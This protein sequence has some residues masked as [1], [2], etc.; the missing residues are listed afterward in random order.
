L[1]KETG[2]EETTKMLIEGLGL[3]AIKGI[4]AAGCATGAWKT[5]QSFP[6]NRARNKLMRCFKLGEMCVKSKVTRG[7]KQQEVKKYPSIEKVEIL[8]DRLKI[9]FTVPLG[10]DPNEIDKHMWLFKQQ[11]G[12]HVE[13]EGDIRAFKVIVFP[14]N[15]NQYAYAYREF[16]T[17]MHEMR[18]PIIAGRSRTGVVVYDMSEHPHL[19]IAALTG[20]GKSTQLRAILTSLIQFFSPDQ[21]HL[22]LADLKRSEFHIFEDVAHVKSSVIEKEEFKFMLD[23]VIEIMK[24][25]GYLLREHGESHIWDLPSGQ[26]PPWVIVCVDEL[27]EVKKETEILD[28]VEKIGQQG[29][30]LG[31]YLITSMQRPDHKLLDG[32][33]KQSLTVRM[34]FRQSDAV[35]SG[36][37][38]DATGAEKLTQK[39]LMLLKHPDF[40]PFERIQGPELE[41]NKA[42]KI[43]ASYKIEK[44]KEETQ[45]NKEDGGNDPVG[46]LG[47]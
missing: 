18:L 23:E 20:W 9:H 35:N 1:F 43:L 27:A 24:K 13:I 28:R 41:I 12:E 11:F 36:I 29:R 25:R 26:Q 22:Y 2:E 30:A 33:I 40:I 47:D 17:A 42:K 34:S 10:L 37:V 31:V 4:A 45:E 44:E 32:A 39:G 7:K 5:W 8:P 19:L 6:E 38:L 16:E 46:G 15:L 21:L 14:G 3:M